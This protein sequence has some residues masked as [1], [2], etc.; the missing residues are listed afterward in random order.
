[1][2]AGF[3]SVLWFAAINVVAILLINNKKHADRLLN[4]CAWYLFLY[5]TIEYTY[6]NIKGNINAF[7]IEFSA[8]TYFLFSIVHI[9]KIKNLEQLAVFCALL[10]GFFYIITFI[11]AGT[12]MFKYNGGP[13]NA[14]STIFN[15]SVLY[16]VAII[17]MK[18]I[19]FSK[20]EFFKVIVGMGFIVFYAWAMKPFYVDDGSVLFIYRFMDAS[21][22]N[23]II[24]SFHVF[25]KIMPIYYLLIIFLSFGV[26][27]F[28]YK[29]NRKLY[30]YNLRNCY[31]E[32][33]L[34]VEK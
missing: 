15:H 20:S 6:Y 12:S 23:M 24:P 5:K 14:L 33:L 3:T 19:K 10:S 7:P 2:L 22:I 8:V 29:I 32:K 25:D 17:K 16:F 28:F 26:L 31:N 13:L 18:F 27:K 11:L 9:F 34:Y 30:F 4:I 21:I 1:M